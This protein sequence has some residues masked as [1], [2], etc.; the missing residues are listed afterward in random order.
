MGQLV[1]WTSFY[2]SSPQVAGENTGIG[3]VL[4]N[5]GGIIATLT[6]RST[7]LSFLTCHLEAHEGIAHFNNRNKNLIEILGGAK[8]HPDYYMM[9]ASI[10]SHHMFVCGDLNYR[11]RFNGEANDKSKS[12]SR[13][14]LNNS[15][16]GDEDEPDN[17][18]GYSQAMALIGDKNWSDLYAADELCMA[19][20]KK[21]CL[22]G[23]ETLPCDFSPTFKVARE[24][25]YVYNEKRT[26]R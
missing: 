17:G 20:K 5:K 14:E 19:L 16:R 13:K 1:Y 15:K 18:S 23:F 7:R 26:P 2:T 25:G 11:T 21:E 8:P 4:A 9:D 3:S 24:E 22:V 12:S 6:L 10:Y